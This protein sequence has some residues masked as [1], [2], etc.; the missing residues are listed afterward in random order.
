MRRI[1][2]IVG[3]R[4]DDPDLDARIEAHDQS[5]TLERV[6][7]EAEERKKS[8]LRVE[9]DAG[10]DL[11]IITDRPELRSG[12]VLFVEKEAAAIVTFEAREAYVIEL[13]DRD[14]GT[15]A[16]AAKLGHRIGNQHWDIAVEGGSVYVPLEADKRI[17]EEVLEP[18]LPSEATTRY[19]SV[20]PELFIDGAKADHGGPDHEHSDAGPHKD[21]VV[22]RPHNDRDRS[23]S[24]GIDDHHNHE[25]D[26]D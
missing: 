4:S 1:D 23:H 5:G 2:G 15:T 17:I 12:D 13:P 14:A 25:H 19:R 9:T 21:G 26:H 20:D 16:L 22:D 6:A 10:T 7:I 24:H 8:R 11:G 3:N 18:Y